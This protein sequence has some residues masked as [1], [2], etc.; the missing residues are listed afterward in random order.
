MFLLSLTSGIKKPALKGSKNDNYN[1]N[2]D[3]DDDG[4]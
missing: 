2:Y 4:V 1:D 3:G